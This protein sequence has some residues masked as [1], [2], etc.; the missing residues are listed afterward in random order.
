M[1]GLG[2]RGAGGWF[3]PVRRSLGRMA[4][5][6]GLAGAAFLAIRSLLGGVLPDGFPGDAALLAAALV[7]G[8]LC[9]TVCAGL[10]TGL[11]TVGG[12][13]PAEGRE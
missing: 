13:P 9:Y 5:G 10:P 6:A 4:V 12:S 3:L 2:R 8:G 11:R 1:R 7:A